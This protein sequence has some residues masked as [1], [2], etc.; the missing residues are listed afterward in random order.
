MNQIFG[1]IKVPNRVM[2]KEH[3]NLFCTELDLNSQK[4]LTCGPALHTLGSCKHTQT[5]QLLLAVLRV[6][7]VLELKQLTKTELYN[8]Y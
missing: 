6:D 7:E 2:K 5:S 1:N 3:C 8:R 4:G